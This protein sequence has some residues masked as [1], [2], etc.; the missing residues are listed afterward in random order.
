MTKTTVRKRILAIRFESEEVERLSGVCP[1]AEFL[2]ASSVSQVHDLL[3]K[4]GRGD[5]DLL[6]V[7]TLDQD[8]QTAVTECEALRHQESLDGVPLL[9][10]IS[11][12]QIGAGREIGQLRHT[13]FIIQPIKGQELG[14]KMQSFGLKPPTD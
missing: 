8:E 11:R 2:Q 1:D 4:S 13:D 6:L 9:A 7:S 14:K 10:A 12:Y 3:V 5:I